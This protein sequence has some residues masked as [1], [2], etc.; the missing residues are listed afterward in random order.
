MPTLQSVSVSHVSQ[1]VSLSVMSVSLSLCQSCQS[2]CLFVSHV[3][4]CLFVSHVSQSVSLSVMSVSLSLCQ[5][6]QSLCLSPFVSSWLSLLCRH[7]ACNALK[8]RDM[9]SPNTC[10]LVWLLNRSGV[11]RPVITNI[12]SQF[13]NIISFQ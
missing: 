2:V 9:Y 8:P 5:S 1:S 10:S 13:S 11:A 12:P 3:S 6:C 4:Q 7:A